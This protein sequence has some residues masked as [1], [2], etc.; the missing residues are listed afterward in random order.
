MIEAVRIDL[1]NEEDAELIIGRI[2]AQVNRDDRA[3]NVEIL[4]ELF[5]Y[6]ARTPVIRI[7]LD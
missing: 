3:K 5:K 1:R 6:N 4:E 2:L 7:F